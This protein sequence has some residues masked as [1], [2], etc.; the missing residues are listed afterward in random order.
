MTPHAL[1]HGFGALC[2]ASVILV[3]LVVFLGIRR[4]QVIGGAL[5]TIVIGGL[6]FVGLPSLEGIMS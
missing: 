6:L 5:L 2:L 1:F 3:P 4:P